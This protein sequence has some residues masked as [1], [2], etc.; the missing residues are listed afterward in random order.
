MTSTDR[1]EFNEVVAYLGQ[2][3]K[4]DSKNAYYQCPICK[5]TSKDNLVYTFANGL[6]KSWCCTSSKS[7]FGN[8]LKL[9]GKNTT[10]IKKPVKKPE[11]SEE[12]IK[13]YHIYQDNCNNT[14]LKDSKALNF[15]LKKRGI[16]KD[17]VSFCG[18]GIDKIKH[19]WVIP[20]YDV[21]KSI[22]GFEYRK[23]DFSDF[24]ALG[25]SFKCKKE[26][27]SYSC[28]AQINGKALTTEI[29]I[30][31]EGFFDAYLFWQHLKSQGQ[32]EFYH[33]LTPSMGVGTV[34]DLLKNF[35]FSLY[36]KVI[37]Y[38][39]SDDKGISVM[40]EAKK[41]YPFIETKIMTCGCKDFNEH[42]LNCLKNKEISNV[43]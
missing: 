29:A 43:K 37:L 30:I 4:Q 7:I 17:T 31:F 20:I 2:P 11:L 15:L 41:L 34:I 10:S 12:K 18:I 14:L 24:V 39:D 21:K 8:I 5:D 9:R 38:L 32:N 22:S 1:L 33:I 19:C 13:D 3:A 6:L 26:R 16:D 25:R 27:G 40:T 35:D 23:S 42:Y 36:K 28:L